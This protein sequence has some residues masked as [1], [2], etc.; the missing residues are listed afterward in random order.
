[1][2]L[3]RVVDDVAELPSRQRPAGGQQILS[4][5]RLS[6]GYHGNVKGLHGAEG[7]HVQHQRDVRATSGGEGRTEKEFCLF[8]I[9]YDLFQFTDLWIVI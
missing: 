4:G 9:Y 1:M 8:S 5:R 6:G 3:V 2:Q 7:R